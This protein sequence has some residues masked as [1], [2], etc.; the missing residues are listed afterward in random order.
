MGNKDFYMY[1][2]G[3]IQSIPSNAANGLNYIRKFVFGELNESQ[4]GKSFAWFNRDFNE[5]WFH[6]PSTNSDE[7]DKVVRFNI[8]EL[9]WTLDTI[10]RTTAENPDYAT[11]NPYM[12]DIS[13]NIRKHELGVNDDIS[14][15][16]WSLEGPFFQFGNTEMMLDGV[17]PDSKQTGDISVSITTRRLIQSSGLDQVNTTTV[18]PTSEYAK[19]SLPISGRNWKFSWHSDTLGGDWI[20]GDWYQII[21]RDTPK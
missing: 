20:M 14:A 6:Y 1:N 13:N 2:G 8:N 11:S 15:L 21:K 19:S 18:T 16:P 12:V 9:H 4:K 10:D 7:C 5:I 17:I 3:V